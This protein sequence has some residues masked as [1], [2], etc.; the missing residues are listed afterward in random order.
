MDLCKVM[1]IE[2]VNRNV[3]EKFG[4]NDA[5]LLT[6]AIILGAEPCSDRKVDVQVKTQVAIDEESV[7]IYD[8]LYPGDFKIYVE[9]SFV[10]DMMPMKKLVAV[11]AGDKSNI[12]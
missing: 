9:P 6:G 10:E 3:T 11:E 7:K 1:Y 5:S 8:M 12:F 2:Q 4:W